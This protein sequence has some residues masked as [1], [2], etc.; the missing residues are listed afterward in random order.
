MNFRDALQLMLAGRAVARDG[1]FNH[2]RIFL[3][4][5]S[6]AWDPNYIEANGDFFA[7]RTSG[8]PLRFFEAGDT[9]TVTRL[10]R[11]DARDTLE[12]TM[13][14]WCPSAADLLAEDWF[15]VDESDD[16]N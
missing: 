16:A 12:H 2:E 13:T 1:D 9:G 10:P 4:K 15:V 6:I 8:I 7:D 14:G 3:V 5:G 11:F